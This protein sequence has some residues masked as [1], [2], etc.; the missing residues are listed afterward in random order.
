MKDKLQQLKD[1]VE[2]LAEE[3]LLQGALRDGCKKH[4]DDWNYHQK[5]FGV[6]YRARLRTE[7]ALEQVE[8]MPR[9]QIPTA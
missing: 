5:M 1:D 4:G 7:I 9:V 3:E 8:R 2:L 6:F